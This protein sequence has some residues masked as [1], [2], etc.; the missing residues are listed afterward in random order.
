VEMVSTPTE[1]NVLNGYLSK[2]TI[3][4]AIQPCNLAGF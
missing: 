4:I 2:I 1:N 3:L